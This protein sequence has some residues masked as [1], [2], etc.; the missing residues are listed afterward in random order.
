[1]NEWSSHRLLSGLI[2]LATVSRDSNL[3]MTAFIRDYLEEFG[4]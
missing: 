3:E 2:G 4:A 1:M